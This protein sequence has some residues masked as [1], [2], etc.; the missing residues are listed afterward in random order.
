MA[1]DGVMSFLRLKDVTNTRKTH[2]AQSKN[3]EF[4]SVSSFQLTPKQWIITQQFTARA[5]LFLFLTHLA[6]LA[7]A[8]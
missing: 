5:D 4:F 3:W 8:K 7:N 2:P 1:L 6:Y